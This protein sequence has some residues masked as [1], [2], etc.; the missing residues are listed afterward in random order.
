MIYPK[1]IL[2]PGKY[3]DNSVGSGKSGVED[4]RSRQPSTSDVS[5]WGGGAQTLPELLSLCLSCLTLGK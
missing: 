1:A 4:G 5:C 3:R 2:C